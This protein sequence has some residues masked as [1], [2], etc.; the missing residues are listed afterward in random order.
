MFID[1]N[2]SFLHKNTMSWLL[3]VEIGIL[4]S[5]NSLGLGKIV[6]TQ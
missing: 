6:E 1:T 5:G 3:R 4:V 2:Q